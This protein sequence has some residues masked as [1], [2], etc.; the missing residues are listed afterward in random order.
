MGRTDSGQC[1]GGLVGLHLTARHMR[2]MDPDIVW[3]EIAA[4]WGVL[5]VAGP[6]GL[7]PGG[8]VWTVPV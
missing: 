6:M 2:V 8:D 1:A 3:D 7:G 5:W 4:F